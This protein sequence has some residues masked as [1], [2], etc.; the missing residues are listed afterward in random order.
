MPTHA[1]F[2]GDLQDGLFRVTGKMVRQEF[3][4]QLIRGLVADGRGRVLA[5]VGGHSLF[6]QSSDGKWTEMPEANS[7][8]LSCVPIRLDVYVGTDDARVLRVA[9]DGVVQCLT[10]FDTIAGA[11]RGTQDQRRQWQADGA[12]AWNSY[13]GGDVR[14][15]RASGK[16][17]RRRNSAIK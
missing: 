2:G 12:A 9:S 3:A 11:T 4:S 13:H 17:P 10:G 1:R 5:I 8:F 16:R 6:R 15:C 7:S 14:W